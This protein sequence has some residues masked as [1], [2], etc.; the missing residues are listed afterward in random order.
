MK[1]NILHLADLH[2]NAE[3]ELYLKNVGSA[4]CKDLANQVAAGIN[5]D[6]V[7][8]TGDLVN[9]GQN[10]KVEYHL[11]ES[12]FLQ[13]L[14]EVLELPQGAF[15]FVPGN[16]DVDQTQVSKP[17]ESGLGQDLVDQNAFRQ[18]Y[19]TAQG[20]N[21]DIDFLQKKLG[22]YFNFVSGYKNEHVKHKSFFYDAYKVKKN[23]IRVGIVSLNSAWR[24]SQHGKDIGRLVIGEHVVMEAAA[25]ISDCDIRVC[26]CHHPFEMLTEWDAKPVR[27]MVA[28]H[29]HALLNGH[30][31]D[32]DAAAT[33]QL[34]GNLFVS[35]AGCLKPNEQFSSY[36]TIEMDLEKE[37]I[38]CHFRKWYSERGQFD[39]E[40]A[41]AAKGQ[42]TFSGIRTVSASAS[43]VLQIAVVRGRLQEQTQELDVVCPIE[44]IEDVEFGDVFVEPLLSD[45][46]AYDRDTEA[47]KTLC[48]DDLLRSKSNL[49][50]AGR[51][52]FGKT[53][54]LR[55]ARDFI[56]RHDKHFDTQIPVSLKFS[57]LPKNNP[58]STIRC[59]AKVLGL[60][61]GE[62]ESFAQRGQLALLIDDFNDRQDIDHEKRVATLRDFSQNHSNC[63][64]ILSATEYLSQPLQ[65]ELLTLASDF[66]A[67]IAYIGS[68]NTAHTRQLLIKWKAKHDFDVDGM[69]HQILYYFQHC[70]IPVTP[71]AVV[72]FLGVLFRTKKEKNIRNEAF[73][74]E[75]YLETI[76]EKLSPS[77][78][79][80]ESDFH[81][82]EDFLAAVAWEMVQRGKQML[83][84]NEFEQLKIDYFEKQDEDLPHH[85]FFEA[86]FNKG[87]L[88][89][90]EGFV[91][92]RRR[93]WFHFFLAKALEYDKETEKAFL[94]RPDVLK[95]SKALAYKAG[96]SRKE[97][98]LLRWVDERAMKEAQPFIK[99]Y[100]HFELKDAGKTA[101]LQLIGDAIAQELREKNT[102]EEIDRRR[103][104]IFLQYQEDRG[105]IDEEQIEN[106]DDLLSLQSDI[107][108]NTTKI[109]LN[110]KRRFIDNNVSCYIALMWAGLE[111]FR[112]M[113][114]KT[115]ETELF[116]LF[117]KGKKDATMQQKLRVVI[118]QAQ[119]IVH[120]VVPL[121]VLVYMNEH[122]G[123]PKLSKS[124]RKLAESSHSATKRLFYYLLIFAQKPKEGIKDL[125]MMITPESSTTEDFII[126]G[127]LRW[128]CYENKVDEDLLNKIVA[129]LDSV[130]K[131]YAKQVKVNRPKD[132]RPFLR[133]TF[134]TDVKKLLQSKHV[135]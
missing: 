73:L 61:D 124:L 107:I 99:K 93:F 102:D 111:M 103:D 46:S 134:R 83:G 82:K 49:L 129:I 44:G 90:D 68:L 19:R 56:L 2:C 115:D 114:Q 11:A 52:E 23:G 43:A 20:N 50:L 6:I 33:R 42:S 70:Q 7:C 1:L 28:K 53:T 133:D 116:K 105:Q 110:E 135:V 96:L 78:R 18:F 94:A 104:D 16:H 35:T 77:Q 84:T 39:Q 8:I 37:S 89:R 92:F 117:F 30:V 4:L 91:C 132:D 79:D 122:L 12:I 54:I 108:R 14:R 38:T 121:S 76:L 9:K 17:F 45:K 101:P 25:K 21:P 22:S 98:D 130:R 47:R 120:Q 123:N 86:F 72:L 64:Y 36:T 126:C 51:P 59:I 128:Y 65:F 58:K 109:G 71:L 32:S 55:Y 80:S 100:L 62:I 75:N 127:F 40:T 27:Q 60:P 10:A 34:F 63:R 95:F 48:L 74:I 66:K 15:F 119:R 13:P 31:H 5:P 88:I 118:E 29:F 69:L 3:D 85:S 131:K 81:D 125:K 41:K 24:S 112:E 87:I 106:F 26:L 57:D 113:L 97:I 67:N